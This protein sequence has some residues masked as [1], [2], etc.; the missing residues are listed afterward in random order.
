MITSGTAISF[1]Q[2]G[3]SFYPRQ[4]LW[5]PLLSRMGSFITLLELGGHNGIIANTDLTSKVKRYVR[6][7]LNYENL[8]P[9]NTPKH[10]E[11]EFFYLMF[12]AEHLVD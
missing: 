1:L 12:R 5:L 2:L 9:A 11:R 7:L 10:I 3:D 6:Q 4:V 8:L